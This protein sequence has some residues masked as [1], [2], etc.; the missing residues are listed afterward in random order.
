MKKIITSGSV[1]LLLLIVAG[2]STIS[3][4]RY[5]EK[6]ERVDV[7]RFAYPDE[8]FTYDM[9]VLQDLADRVRLEELT[10]RNINSILK[11]EIKAGRYNEIIIYLRELQEEE[12]EEAAAFSTR[13]NE[14]LQAHVMR[15]A[16]PSPTLVEDAITRLEYQ[17]QLDPENERYIIDLANMLIHSEYDVERGATLLFDL[18]EKMIQAGEQ[19]GLDLTLALAEAYFAVGKYEESIE[20]FERLTTLDTEDPT[21]FYKMSKVFKEMGDKEQ[22]RA[23]LTQAL[24]PTSEFLTQYGDSTYHLYKDCLNKSIYE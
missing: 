19:P 3:M 18:E 22:E 14:A 5:I 23:A 1:L 15:S 10:T 21:Y 12:P 8:N 6:E 9:E 7:E 24:E 20:R 11:D 13:Y 16:E 2:C 17:Y 4:N